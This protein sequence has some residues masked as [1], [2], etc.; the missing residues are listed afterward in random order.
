M[1]VKILYRKTSPEHAPVI[2]PLHTT[3]V[4]CGQVRAARKATCSTTATAL[5]ITERSLDHRRLEAFHT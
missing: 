3:P 4:R 2:E 5:Y 1:E